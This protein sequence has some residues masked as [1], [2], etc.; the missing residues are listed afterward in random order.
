M[1]NKKNELTNLRNNKIIFIC[2]IIFIAFFV[3]ICRIIYISVKYKDEATVAVANNELNRNSTQGVINPVRGNIYDTNMKSMATSYSEYNII[4]DVRE[5]NK[6]DKIEKKEY[7]LTTIGEVLGIP[8]DVMFSYLAVDEE[9]N[10]IYDTNYLII[11]RNQPIEVVNELKETGVGYWYAEE[12]PKRYYPYD[13]SAAQV[14]GFI[15]PDNS[16]G[17]EEQYNSYM[18]GVAGRNFSSMN[19]KKDVVENTVPAEDGNYIVTTID[20]NIQQF[21]DEAVEQSVELYNPEHVGVVVMDPN[22]GEILAM[23]QYPT[24]NPNHPS[25]TDYID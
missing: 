2:I 20:M 1:R 14:V 12:I 19:S 9:G 13:S 4:L 22:T 21:A 23:S 3:L 16:Y 24:F 11:A 6:L 8:D 18:T 5:L 25:D 10:L 15:R 7:I 17:L